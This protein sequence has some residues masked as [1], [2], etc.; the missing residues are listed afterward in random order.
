MIW[1]KMFMHEYGHTQQGMVFGSA[2]GIPSAIN[3]N[4]SNETHSRRWCEMQAN[5]YVSRY[6]GR[7][8]GVDWDD[9]L[10]LYRYDNEN[11]KHP[12]R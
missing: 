2:I 7:F 3:S 4:F 11:S 9:I 6:F 12:L 8:H 5:R 10:R 1:N